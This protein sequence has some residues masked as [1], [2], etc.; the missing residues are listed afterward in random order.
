M[1]LEITENIIRGSIV[2]QL[3]TIFGEDYKYYDEEIV[4]D[5]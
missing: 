5:F 1:N 2:N 3:K 4:Q